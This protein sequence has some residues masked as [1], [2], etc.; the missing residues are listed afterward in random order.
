[1]R[2]VRMKYALV[3]VAVLL[4]SFT[5]PAFGQVPELDVTAVCTARSVDTT[6]LQPTSGQNIADC[7]RDEKAAKQQL[8]TSWT[9]A[10]VPTRNRCESDARALGTTS[11][12]D[13]LA[14][15]QINEDTKSAPKKEA[16]KQ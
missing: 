9:S 6:T 10:S 12:L 15:I 5:P 2:E 16:G 8:S 7:V 14:C 3:L 13:L 11:Y 1:M 4:P